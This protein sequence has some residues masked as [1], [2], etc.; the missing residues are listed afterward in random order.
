MAE[1]FA[2][3]AYLN[4]TLVILFCYKILK[5]GDLVTSTGGRE[6]WFLYER[7]GE[8]DGRVS[9]DVYTEVN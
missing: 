7:E 5:L 3:L 8:W 4:F 1:H 6:T 9:T 2:S